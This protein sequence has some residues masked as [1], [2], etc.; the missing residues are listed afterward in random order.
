MRII[1]EFREF[2]MKG[3][4]IDLA[5]AV[6]IGAAFGKIITALVD[7]ILMPIIGSFSSNNFASLIVKVNGVD[8]KYGLFL[9]AAADFIIVAFVLFIIVKALNKIKRK[10]EGKVIFGPS[11]TEQ[12]LTEIRD[13]L[14]NKP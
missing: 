7:N 4:I 10:K 11:S 1:K 9:Q 6:M 8:I 3:N 5:I 14:K 2:A 12:L 13:I